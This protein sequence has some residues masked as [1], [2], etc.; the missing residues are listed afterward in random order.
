M[1]LTYNDCIKEYGN[2][3]QINKRIASQ[4][5]FKIQKGLYT[6]ERYASDLSIINHLFPNAVLTMRNALYYH[7]LTDVVPDNFDLM[8]G[9]NDSKIR[10][11]RIKQYFCPKHLLNIGVEIMNYNGINIRVYSKE[12]MMI[13]LIR[14]KDK[15]PFAYY[16]EV[17]SHYRDILYELNIE[18]LQEWIEI[19]P[20]SQHIS[21]TIR[22]E[23]F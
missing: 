1:L 14:Y 4:E 18:T 11:P 22:A 8:T 10:S 3:Y 23:V 19:F 13:E 15:L 12:R 16:K 21:K 6:N 9:R 2:V 7:G 5:L 17:L 20:K